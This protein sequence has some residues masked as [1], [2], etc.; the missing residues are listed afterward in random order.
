M[1]PILDGF[2]GEVISYNTSKS[3]NLE[4]INDMLN[5]A[6]DKNTNLEELIFHSDQGC[7]MNI[8]LISKD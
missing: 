8:N 5:K 7:N 1:S 6:F 4:Q 2:N 3:P